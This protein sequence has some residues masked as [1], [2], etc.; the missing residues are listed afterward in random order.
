[1]SENPVIDQILDSYKPIW[2][3]NH[4]GGLFEWDLETYMPVDAAKSRGIAQAQLALIRQKK[5]LDL[6]EIVSKAEKLDD[7]SDYEKGVVRNI[8]RELKYFSKIPPELVE[9]LQRTTTEASVVW[10][11]ARRKSDFS[12]FEPYLEK[13]VQLKRKEADKLGYDGHPYNALMDIFE[14]DLTTQDVD[15]VFSPLVP[16]LKK[17]LG[18]IVSSKSFPSSHKLEDVAYDE[19][20]MKRVNQEVLKILGM[21]DKTFRMDISTHPF[22][23]GM[24]LDD[25]RITTRYEGKSFRE[26]I[27]SV[28]HECGH[29]LYDLQ[30]D[31]SLEYTPLAGGASLGI[32]ESQSR[33]WENFVGR[34]REFTNLLYP[35]LKENLTFISEY[36]EA[37]I[38]EYF[39]L[40]RPSLIRVAADEITYNFHIVV[41]YEVEKK[42]IGGEAKVSEIPE[43]WDDMMEEY[44]GVRPEN[45]A[46]GV[47][48]DVHWSGGMIGYFPTYSLG[49]VIAG[50]VSNRMRRDLNI[51]DSIARGDLNSMKM[52]LKENIH[53]WGS[54]YSP[55]ELQKKV[56]GDVYNPEYLV[57]YLEEK[58]LA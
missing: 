40:V 52:W 31:H 23:A 9:E 30:V 10:R 2:A 42:L 27:F 55:K 17:I 56:L 58:Y 47:L 46:E 19:E 37:D 38:Y 33:F 20:I 43:I 11:E 13:I 45:L 29:A 24:S 21:P 53:K 32:H 48:Q 26:T 49:N 44:V 1:M 50:M 41:R 6:T 51:P 12:L 35:I 22:T 18:R 8:K 5:V 16:N 4:A 7:L 15:R 39:N 34:S 3:L 54:I 36:S 14:E 25:V 28:I 57:K